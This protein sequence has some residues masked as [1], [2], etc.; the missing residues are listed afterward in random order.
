MA[1]RLTE[2][3]VKTLEPPA[4][5]NAITYDDQVAGFGIRVTAA[6]AKA[7]TLTYRV[8]R[9]ERRHTIGA[10]RPGV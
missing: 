5:G 3:L 10:G 9:I 6:G 2:L 4:R 7:F 1:R 8:A